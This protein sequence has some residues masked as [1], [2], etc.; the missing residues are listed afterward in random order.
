M[1]GEIAT[2]ANNPDQGEIWNA[3]PVRGE[4]GIIVV[5]ESQIQVYLLEGKLGI[6]ITAPSRVLTR[7]FSST[8]SR[9][10]SCIP[11]MW[12]VVSTNC[13]TCHTP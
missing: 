13:S 9:P 11:T 5:P 4:V 12:P 3:R 6:I 8:I 7:D 1:A 10:I 2:W